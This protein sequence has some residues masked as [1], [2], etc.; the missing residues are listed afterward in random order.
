MIVGE[1]CDTQTG[2]TY[3]QA[4]RPV[5]F[6]MPLDDPGGAT[7]IQFDNWWNALRFALT[8]AHYNGCEYVGGPES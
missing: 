7:Y 2:W 6:V 3:T 1:I 8:F 4:G 5:A